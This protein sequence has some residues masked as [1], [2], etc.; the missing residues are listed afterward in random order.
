M[1]DNRLRET[2]VTFGCTAIVAGLFFRN[3]PELQRQLLER[4]AADFLASFISAAAE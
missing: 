3:D 1:N 2:F 4:P